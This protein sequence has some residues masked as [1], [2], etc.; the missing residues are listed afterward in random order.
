MTPRR[1]T[2]AD[3]VYAALLGAQGER[4]GPAARWSRTRR[5]LELLGDPQRTYRVVPHHGHERQDL[6]EPHDREPRCAPTA[7]APG[8]SRARTSSASPSGS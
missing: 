6:D 4:L 5:V 2:R 1:A 3:A 7:C 8:C